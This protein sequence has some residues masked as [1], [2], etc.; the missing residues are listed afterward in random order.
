MSAPTRHEIITIP[1]D[2]PTLQQSWN[3][4]S[5]TG[6]ASRP[7][8][9]RRLMTRAGQRP[10]WLAAPPPLPR[11][12][13][14]AVPSLR[15]GPPGPGADLPAG[16]LATVRLPRSHAVR[17]ARGL[18]SFVGLLSIEGALLEAND[19]ALIRADLSACDA[20]GLPFWDAAWWSWSPTVQDRVRAALALVVAGA[21]VRYDE[22]ALVRRN[23]LI[24]VDLA[25]APLARAGAVTAVVCSAIDL[26][27]RRAAGA[28]DV[29]SGRTTANG[30]SS[31]WG[32]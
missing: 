8:A 22:T 27:G 4:R 18:A 30:S 6:P 25:W 24:T 10:R 20:I 9:F 2:E 13:A 14:V 28:R 17:S 5:P 15:A 3:D 11:S 12:S 31:A 32:S 29:E 19:T 21:T 7:R 26:G 23:Q 16:V 1:D